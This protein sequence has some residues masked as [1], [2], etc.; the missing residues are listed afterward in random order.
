VASPTSSRSSKR[1]Q[2]D[3]LAALEFHQ[4]RPWVVGFLL[5][6]KFILLSY[7]AA[8]EPLRAANTLARREL[9]VWR[10]ICLDTWTP[11]AMT[12]AEIKVD[13][14]VGDDAKFDL[15]VVCS[16]V[17][18]AAF[19][20]KATF[21]WLR[22]LA[23]RGI[24]IAGIGGGI[25]IMAR[26]GLLDGYR[27]AVHWAQ[28]PDFVEEFPGL[29]VEHSL[30][31]VDGKRITCSGGIAPMDLMHAII[32]LQ[33][34]HD[35]ASAVGDW[36]IHA[37]VRPETDPQR[38]SLR[39]RVGVDNPSLLRVIAAME[40][41]LEEV[42]SRQELA[43]IGGVSLRQLERLFRL[44]LRSTIASY[45]VGLRLG[46]SRQ[47]LRKTSRSITEI[48]MASGFSSLS[49]FSRAYKSQYGHSPARERR[50]SSLGRS[51]AGNGQ[52]AL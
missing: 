19:R 24:P 34:G 10:H 28:T 31:V 14:R 29:R 3:S 20:D 33:H 4:A 44:Q 6:P 17:E 36:F 51:M 40:Q 23:H 2:A 16:P 43:S 48:A 21:A 50:S 30:Y 52:I 41:H 12:G 8:I 18:Y 5:P 37:E 13:H 9:Y 45:Y 46:H 47:L 49:Y 32:A 27:C 7:A 35:L 38:T 42:L 25:H 22:K 26:A 11:R 15:L 1:K 39:Y